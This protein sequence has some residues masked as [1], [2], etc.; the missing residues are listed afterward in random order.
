MKVVGLRDR[1]L[2]TGDGNAEEIEGLLLDRGELG[3]DC[4]WIVWREGGDHG[5]SGQGHERSMVVRRTPAHRLKTSAGQI[6]RFTAL[7]LRYPA[8]VPVGQPS[9]LPRPVKCDPG[10]RCNPLGLQ[11]K[12]A[13][14]LALCA[15]SII[16]DQFLAHVGIQT[17]RLTNDTKL[18]R[19]LS[20]F[21][22]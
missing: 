2:A 14:A 20:L 1:L 18:T 8:P 3:C 13:P 7:F 5:V 15:D 9:A 10:F 6:K 12:A 11:A 21:C 19:R 16:G 17:P 22:K 4:E